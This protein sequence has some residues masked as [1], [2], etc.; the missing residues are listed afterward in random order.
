MGH[1]VT[2]RIIECSVCRKTPDDGEYLWEMSGEY[3]CEDCCNK[4]DEEPEERVHNAGV[5]GAELA[6]RPR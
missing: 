3:W 2:Q 4:D 1:R 5:T 6:K